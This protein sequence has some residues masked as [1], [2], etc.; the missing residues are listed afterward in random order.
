M[1]IFYLTSVLGPKGGSEIYV[2][3]I[4]AELVKRGH[5]VMVCSTEVHDVPGAKMMYLP[6]IGHHALHKFQAILFYRRVLKAARKFKPDIVQSHSNSMMG[7]LGHMVKKRLGIPHI[8]LIELISSQNYTLHAKAI[9]QSE[10]FLLPKLNYDKL[11]IWTEHMKNK[12]LLPWGIP[13]KKIEVINAAITVENYDLGLKGDW[14]RKK[15]GKN[16]VVSFKT[17]WETNAKGIEYIIRA[18]EIVCKKH[19]DWKYI[20]FGGGAEKKNLEKIVK[21]LGLEKN[22]KF[23]GHVF[24]RQAKDVLAATDIAPHSFVYEF[25]TSISLLEY[26]AMGKACVVTDVGSVREFVKDAGVI[27]EAENPEAIAE[28]INKLIENPKLRKE[29]GKKARKL[30]EENYSINSTINRLEKIYS[31]AMK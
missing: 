7:L 23:H 29:L 22:I 2:R 17:L 6:I 15:Y 20:V 18:M 31:E 12:F 3:D 24:S 11:V 30:V 5:E 27:V 19:S 4:I 28:G 26:L 8:L 14:V 13:E 1:R 9:F 25:S 10:K 16:L 21:K